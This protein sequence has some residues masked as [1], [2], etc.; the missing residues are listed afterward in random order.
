MLVP[1]LLPVRP[2]MPLHART[3][4]MLAMGERAALPLPRGSRRHRCITVPHHPPHPPQPHPNPQPPPT[5]FPPSILSFR[6]VAQEGIS[7][8]HAQHD[9]ATYRL[10]HPVDLLF[11]D[12][13]WVGAW[14]LAR[15]VGVGWGRLPSAC[16]TQWT[17][18]AWPPGGWAC[19][20]KQIAKRP[21]LG[22]AGGAGGGGGGPG[23][24]RA[25]GFVPASPS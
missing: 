21:P 3:S 15:W 25:M 10:P 12:T 20:Q 5:P 11:I 1:A 8:I 6:Q 2:V 17:C 4:T 13:W 7:L 23:G 19:N 14:V 18:S 9:S 22:G 24:E 16:P